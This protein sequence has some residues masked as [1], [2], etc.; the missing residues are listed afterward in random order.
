MFQHLNPALFSSTKSL[1]DHQGNIEGIVHSHIL[2]KG[3][4]FLLIVHDV[5]ILHLVRWLQNNLAYIPRPLMRK[6]RIRS[7]VAEYRRQ[8]AFSA[9]D[10]RWW[11]RVTYSGVRPAHLAHTNPFK[12]RCR[13]KLTSECYMCTS[14][15]NTFFIRLLEL[16]FHFQEIL[17]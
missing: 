17:C 6:S 5:E 11:R 4:L 14:L 8:C 16:F 12:Y 13:W 3:I 15:L 7:S 9:T 10:E 1:A 2:L